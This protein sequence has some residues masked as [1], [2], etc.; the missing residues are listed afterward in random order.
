MKSLNWRA[1]TVVVLALTVANLGFVRN[2]QA[3]VVGTETLVQTDRNAQLAAV[4]AQLNRADVRAAFEKLGVDAAAID[5]RVAKL[6][7][8]ELA[9][10][11][12]QM[13]DAPAGGDVFAL[14]G[15]VFVVL[16]IL[17]LV[18]VIDIFKKIP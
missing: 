11:S 15:V 4:Q 12:R 7:D 1:T 16:L 3:G 10:L 13:Q 9:E 6:G 17:E 5:E 8:S 2:A 14:I 18:G